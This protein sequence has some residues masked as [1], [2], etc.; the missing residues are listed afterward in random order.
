MRGLVKLLLVCFLFLPSAA[1]A[2]TDEIAAPDT[3][4][5]AQ[6]SGTSFQLVADDGAAITIAASEAVR[7]FGTTIPGE[8]T[9]YLEAAGG[10]SLTAITLSGLQ[11]ATTYY[12]YVDHLFAQEPVVADE[13]GSFTVSLDLSNPV[14]FIVKARPSTIFLRGE[15]WVDG[16]GIP[17]PA[18]WSH[19][20][21]ADLNDVV[22]A[23]DAETRTATLLTDPT[24]IIEIIGSNIT[25][26]GNGHSCIRTPENPGYTRAI[27][28]N[29]VNYITIRNLTFSGFY[30]GIA[31]L[32]SN[33]GTFENLHFEGND[34]GILLRGM[35]NVVGNNTFTN[36]GRGIYLY[37]YS[38]Y[39]KIKNSQFTGGDSGAYFMGMTMSNEIFEN[40]FR[41]CNTGIN[42]YNS[43]YNV[44]YKNN[45]EDN[46]TGMGLSGSGTN[47]TSDY[48][49][50]YNNNFV[51]NNLQVFVI[52]TGNQFNLPEPDGGNYFSDWTGPD[53]NFDGFVD[54]PYLIYHYTTATGYTLTAQDNLPYTTMYGWVDNQAPVF[55]AVG[56]QEVFAYSTLTFPL[57]VT[58]PDGDAI[59]AVYAENL[60]AG[61]TFD[62]ASGTFQWQPN[63][64]QAGVYVVSFFAVDDGLPSQT[65]Q[66]DVVI[67][68]GEVQSPVELT[69]S[70]VAEIA[71]QDFPTEVQSSYTANV[72]KVDELLE[73]GNVGAV[74]NQ[75]EVLLHKIDQ[76]LKAGKI[77]QE[78][79][80]LLI[81]M[82]NDGIELLNATP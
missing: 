21:G 42:T 14:T 4:G 22:G 44:I 34:K 75:Y 36:N 25:L 12:T 6:G 60:P 81:M 7:L 66:L 32:S 69:T 51:N 52:G 45:I 31:I 56:T 67:T 78:E 74:V 54:A 15:P 63:G 48:N 1:L 80:N 59:V 73:K 40:D 68:V 30:E 19:S 28:G 24:E 16:A 20:D 29:G 41:Q 72:G 79:A 38:Y 65:G 8:F 5:I 11:P 49:Q 43:D 9:L 2:W 76:D 13:E 64:G 82:A 3:I 18:G 57:T 46:L 58:D 61:A 53:D 10:Q 77:T 70:M 47:A 33:Y 55:A 35:F 50:V 62:A 71:A 39:N 26:D 37:P 17:H 27:Y 23:W